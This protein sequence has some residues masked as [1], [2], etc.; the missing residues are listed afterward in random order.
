M[1]LGIRQSAARNSAANSLPDLILASQIRSRRHRLNYTHL[2]SM[3]IFDL[4]CR[5]FG[6]SNAF[7]PA[8]KEMWPS[9]RS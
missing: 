7:F 8:V 2:I 9:D 4:E 5:L 1:L 3:T 6:P